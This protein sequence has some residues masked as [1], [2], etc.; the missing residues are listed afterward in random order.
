MKLMPDLQPATAKARHTAMLVLVIA[1]A[2]TGFGTWREAKLASSEQI[3]QWQ[4][5]IS[6]LRPLLTPL[7]DGR[8]ATLQDQAVFALRGEKLSAPAWTNFVTAAEWQWRFP[9]MTEIG[10]ADFDGNA[11]P[12]RFVTSAQSPPA[13]A[14]GFDLNRDPVIREAVQKTAAAGYGI[15]SR[16]V[17]LNQG[18]NAERVI[19][20]LLPVLKHSAYPGPP[21]T[22]RAN[23]Q[24]LIF[25]ALDQQKFFAACQTQL[26]TLPV[27]LRLLDADEPAPPRTA[28][29]RVIGNG[30]AAG[31][32]RF[33]LRMKTAPASARLP[34]WTVLT[35]GA[36]LS[37]LL[38]FLFSAQ[39]RLRLQAESAH[40][41]IVQR[42]T[43]ITGLNR[44][45]EEKIATRTAELNEALAEEKE[46]NRLKSN[47]ISMVTHEI[48]TPLG[49]IL[50]SS[51]ILSRYL[52]RLPPEKRANHLRTIDSAVER[53]S[54]LMEDVLLFSKAEAGRMEFNPA[55]LDLRAFCT[56][57]LD[58]L[59]SATN[60]R[61]P[62]ELHVTP[63]PV[64]RA[65]E[66]LLRHIFA[67]LLTN[68]VKYSPPGT[69]VQFSVTSDRGEAVFNVRDQGM[70]ISEEDRKRLFT[71]FC[72]GR[73]VATIQGTGLGLVIVKHCVEQHGGTIA[74][75]S[76]EAGGTTVTVR[77]PLFSPAHTEF[78]R[79][80][81]RNENS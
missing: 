47:F 23:L 15:G 64:A 29:Q 61:C 52:D 70:G 11:A 44:N 60:R 78:V 53:L 75:A 33:L 41:T 5:G 57:L 10:Y 73:N 12:V 8:L 43:E 51:E 39:A 50:S 13:H 4:N 59:T 71:P 6:Q 48:R 45:L 49:L 58:E 36:A 31:Q 72:R 76:S 30:G 37:F 26:K 68:A 79:R 46:L 74:I 3:I 40:A 25:F 54:S 67:N 7:L 63:C 65:D 69:P 14:P 22:N 34:E 24:G 17:S 38:Y 16:T 77:L 62:L 9:G 28:T 80:Q 32:W 19:I 42:E 81:S 1:L 55:D 27:E 18:T 56:Q 2:A 35:G 21:A 20:G 66:K